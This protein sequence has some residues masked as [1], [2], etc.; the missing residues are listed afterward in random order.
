MRE[1][2]DEIAE[3]CHEIVAD[4]YRTGMIDEAELREFEDGCFIEAKESGPEYMPEESPKPEL[5]IA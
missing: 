3:V 4:G 5:A 2:R 1:Y